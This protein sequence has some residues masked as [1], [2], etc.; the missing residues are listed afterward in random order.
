MDFPGG[1]QTW[2]NAVGLI[3]LVVAGGAELFR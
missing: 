1:R 2:V 3:V